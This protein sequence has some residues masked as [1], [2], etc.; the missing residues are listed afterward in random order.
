MTNH[1]F[2]CESYIFTDTKALF[3][4]I[5]LIFTPMYSPDVTV[6]SLPF[7]LV[8]CLIDLFLSRLSVSNDLRLDAIR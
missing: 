5:N 8:H 3:E 1:A 7:T 6:G 4:Q 2:H